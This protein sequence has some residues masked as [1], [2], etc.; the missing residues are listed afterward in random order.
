[1]VY[2]F[3][4]RA[5]EKEVNQIMKIL[6]YYR[7]VSGEMVNTDKCSVF[8]SKNTSSDQVK[9]VMDQLGNMKVVKHSKY[10]GLS[11]VVGRSKCQILSYIKDKVDRRM[12]NW[13]GKFFS[14]AGKEVLLKS[15]ILSIPKYTMACFKIPKKICK[16]ISSRMAWF[17]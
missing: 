7:R 8:F 12:Q 1:M 17:W 2:S 6:D 4:C 3:F 9:K 13:K 14:R 16:A 10:L 11:I 15:V 5:N